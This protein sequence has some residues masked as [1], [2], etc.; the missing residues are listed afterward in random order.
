MGSEMCIRDR[1]LGVQVA[2]VPY[3]A[4]ETRKHTTINTGALVHTVFCTKTAPEPAAAGGIERSRA[5]AAVA[6][7]TAV[8]SSS[9]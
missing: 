9:Q 5:T 4:L 8:S 1:S 3:L 6:A 7:R 2:A